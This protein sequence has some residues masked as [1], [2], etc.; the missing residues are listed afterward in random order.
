MW[1]SVCLSKLEFV[2]RRVLEIPVE[3]IIPLPCAA[4]HHSTFPKNS[5]YVFQT[6][7][8]LGEAFPSPGTV[9]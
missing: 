1:F 6:Y 7:S 9:I 8:L 4:Q 3:K 2:E 5:Y